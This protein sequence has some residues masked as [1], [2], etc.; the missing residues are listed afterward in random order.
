MHNMTLT[1]V[2][3]GLPSSGISQGTIYR[4]GRDKVGSPDPPGSTRPERPAYIPD[5]QR[6]LSEPLKP[7]KSE[8]ISVLGT[9]STLTER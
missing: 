2:E 3:T 1:H 4:S 9:P 7:S 6:V 8:L 5:P